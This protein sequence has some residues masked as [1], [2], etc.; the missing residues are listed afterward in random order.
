[1]ALPLCSLSHQALPTHS[2]LD[3]P[4]APSFQWYCPTHP[5]LF[6]GMWPGLGVLTDGP[7]GSSSDG[8]QFLGPRYYQGRE[9]NPAGTWRQAASHQLGSCSDAS[10]S[11]A[12]GT[13]TAQLPLWLGEQLG[14]IPTDSWVG[15]GR[16]RGRKDIKRTGPWCWLCGDRLEGM[17]CGMP[18]PG[19]FSE[20]AQATME[21]KLPC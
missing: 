5:N 1:M 14:N 19:V 15:M 17:G 7:C 13:I 11:G 18:Q 3:S 12:C 6:H 21:E 4:Q 8:I 16:Q 9:H 20:A 10:Y 2:P